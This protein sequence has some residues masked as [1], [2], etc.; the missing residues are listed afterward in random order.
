MSNKSF[1]ELGVSRAVVSSLAQQ[2]F[3]EPFEIQRLVIADVLAGRDVLGKS[4]TGSGKTLAFGIPLVDR[5]AADGPRP[6]A[7]V[8]AH[9]HPS[10]VPEPSQAD[11]LI[12]R[13]LRD[14]LALVDI[15]ILD[16]IIV[17]GGEA[18][19]LAEAGL[20]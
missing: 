12:T 18:L 20:L 11:E 14:A 1:A 5:I 10:G 8:L 3:T 17:A 13:R 7:L 15:R 19:S 9:P 16:H 2:G 6:A 4:P